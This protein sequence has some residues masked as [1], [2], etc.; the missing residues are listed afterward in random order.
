MGF[1]STITDKTNIT[2]HDRLRIDKIKQTRKKKYSPDELYLKIVDYVDYAIDKEEVLDISGF[3]LYAHMCRDNIYS[4]STQADYVDT[5]NFLKEIIQN[6]VIQRAFKATNSSFHQFMLKNRFRNDFND[7][8][9]IDATIDN[10]VSINLT[11][12]STSE[13]KQLIDQEQQQIAE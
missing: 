9:T 3:C 8:L 10:N 2:L 7:K 11:T 1:T 13:L 5:I 12:L 6:D 4:Y